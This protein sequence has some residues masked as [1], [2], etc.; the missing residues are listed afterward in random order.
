MVVVVVVV[1]ATV[2][3]V[4]VLVVVT[5]VVVVVVVDNVVVVVVVVCNKSKCKDSLKLKKHKLSRRN[6]KQNRTNADTYI[7]RLWNFK[8]VC[9]NL[10]VCIFKIQVQSFLYDYLLLKAKKTTQVQASAALQ[11]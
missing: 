3:V 4:V 8:L 1:P 2:V 9:R 6:S 7:F 10:H 5:V 11:K